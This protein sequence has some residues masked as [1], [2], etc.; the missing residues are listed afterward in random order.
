MWDK[1]LALTHYFKV[2]LQSE[3][4]KGFNKRQLMLTTSAVTRSTSTGGGKNKYESICLHVSI[5]VQSNNMLYLHNFKA[6]KWKKQNNARSHIDIL[7]FTTSY[8]SIQACPVPRRFMR[9]M[10]IPL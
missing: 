5:Y 1:G 4:G 2:H 7:A 9:F 3:C 10:T 6:A 8:T